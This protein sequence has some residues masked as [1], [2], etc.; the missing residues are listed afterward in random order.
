MALLGVG[1][2]VPA[3]AAEAASA[4]TSPTE[5]I[6]FSRSSTSSSTPRPTKRLNSAED[7]LGINSGETVQRGPSQPDFG[8]NAPAPAMGPTKEQAERMFEYMDRKRNW[9][10]PGASELMTPEKAFAKEGRKKEENLMFMKRS[11][12]VLQ[13]Y[14]NSD[15]ENKEKEGESE[16]GDKDRPRERDRRDNKDENSSRLEMTSRDKNHH[17]DPDAE[18]N[19]IREFDL[20]A[21]LRP[22]GGLR[23]ELREEENIPKA[24]QSMRAELPGR[25]RA[26][27]RDKAAA[28]EREAQRTAEFQELIRPRGLGQKVGAALPDPVQGPDLT[29]RDLNP[30]TPR[31]PL[32]ANKTEITPPSVSSKIQDTRMFGVAAPTAASIAA[33]V[34]VAPQITAPAQRPASVIIEHPKKIF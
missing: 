28:A 9:L 21:Y 34:T 31:A 13:R 19:G 15:R 3:S 20:R 32:T 24:F 11:E 30:I 17:D 27:D 16:T 5:K 8:A 33:P 25:D 7:R 10:V 6:E 4:S 1:G 26:P 2:V 29:R 23:N 12:G 22:G 14:L 18:S